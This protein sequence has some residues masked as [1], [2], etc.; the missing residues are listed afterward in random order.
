MTIKKII[1]LFS[2]FLVMGIV[3]GQTAFDY[4]LIAKALIS[5]GKPDQAIEVLTSAIE[6]QKESKLYTS[7]A[8]AFVSKGDYSSAISDYNTANTLRENSGEYGL[9]RIY[10]IKGDAGTSLYHLERSMKSSFKRSE[11]EILPDPAFGR[12]E[13]RPEWRQFW[14]KEWYSDP[15]KSISE[16]E[17][18]VS[19]GNKV[20][21]ERILKELGRN[22]PDISEIKFGRALIDLSANKYNEA[23]RTLSGLLITDQDNEKYLRA[24]AIAQTGASNPSGAS[25]TYSKLISLDIPDAGLLLERALC[26]RKTGENDKALDDIKKYLSV[27]PGDKSALSLAGKTESAAGNNLKALE[28]FSENLKLHPEDASC[29]TDRANSYLVSRSW[30]WAVTDYSMSLDLDPENSDVWLNKGIALIS[31]GKADDGCHDLRMS[32][33]LGN[34]RATEYISKYCIK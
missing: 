3:A 8:E 10:A 15:E 29:Y 12:I 1:L 33:S 9:S 14:K 24:I 20:E 28:Y 32:L 21:A 27:Y 2:A 19:S 16:I 13:N 30:D 31:S 6:K 17:Y 22:Y 26:F 18:Y 34:K 5:S 11:K 23:I 25:L 7:R 4:L